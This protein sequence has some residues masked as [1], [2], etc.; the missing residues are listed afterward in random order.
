MSIQTVVFRPD[1][2]TVT[3]YLLPP[4]PEFLDFARQVFGA[5]ETHR[6]DTGPGRFHAEIRIG[7]SMLMVGVGSGRSLPAALHVY[8]ENAD[9]TYRRALEAG[10]TSLTEVVEAHGD[11]FGCVQDPAGNHWYIATHLSGHYVRPDLNTVT[12][13]FHPVGAGKFID[14]IKQALGAEEI[15]RYDSPEGVVRHAKIRIGDSAIE[16]S[17]AHDWLQP[18]PTMTYLYVP[19]C[20]ALYARALRAGAKSIHPPSDQFYGDRSGGVEDPFGNQWYMA[21]PIA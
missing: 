4:G 8:V 5:V 20:D 12:T 3:P 10:A 16:V 19:D 7:D 14:F 6:T 13:Y 18:M 2:R 21:T 17:E 9:E 1:F 11:R 15:E